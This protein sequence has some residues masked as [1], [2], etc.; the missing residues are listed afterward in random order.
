MVSVTELLV[1]EGFIDDAWFTEYARTRGTFIHAAR[2]LY[3]MGEL[4]EDDLD[5]VLVPYLSA[6][7]KFMGDSKFVVIASEVR[8]Y[9]EIY[10]FHGKPDA[11]GLL[12]GLPAIVDCK[13]GTIEPWVALQMAGYEILKGT[14]HKRIAVRL[15]SDGKYSIK[16]FNNRQDRQIFMAALACYQWKRNNGIK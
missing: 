13:S 5:P 11:I 15:K 6:W 12:N 3:D 8:L 16:E 14:P 9:N 1:A 7:K 4:D 2:H 10:Q